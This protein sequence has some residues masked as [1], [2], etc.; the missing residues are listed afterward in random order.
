MKQITKISFKN[1]KPDS[2]DC[3]S[4]SFGGGHGSEPVDGGYD[5]NEISDLVALAV[6]VASTMT[7]VYA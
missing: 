5:N 6:V 1:R 2:C 7:E 4:G 3:I